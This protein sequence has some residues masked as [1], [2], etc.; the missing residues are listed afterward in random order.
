MAPLSVCSVALTL[1]ISRTGGRNVP[2][3]LGK[4]PR[5]PN[6]RRN[7]AC[8]LFAIAASLLCSVH[9]GLVAKYYRRPCKNTAHRPQCQ[10]TSLG[11][12]RGRRISRLL[13]SH[14]VSLVGLKVRDYD[15]L[16]PSSVHRHYL[17]FSRLVVTFIPFVVI[18][19]HFLKV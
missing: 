8:T 19:W 11:R 12:R 3:G 16:R 13:R 5:R 9:T 2:I 7:L 17:T 1:D 18:I 15:G 14:Q 6:S 4:E 10:Q